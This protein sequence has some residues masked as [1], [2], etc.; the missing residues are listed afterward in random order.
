MSTETVDE[1]LAA[2]HFAEFFRAVNDLP[3]KNERG[4]PLGPFPWQQAL[5][6]EVGRPADGRT[7]STFPRRQARP[8][9]LTSPCSSW[10]CARTRRAAWSS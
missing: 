9:S 6:E 8:R 10:R 1:K 2:A 3:A 4:V 7:F 5:L